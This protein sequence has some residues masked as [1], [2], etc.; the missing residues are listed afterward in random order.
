[1]KSELL[2]YLNQ[3]IHE[4]EQAHAPVFLHF[5]VK[6]IGFILDFEICV[7]VRTNKTKNVWVYI[8]QTEI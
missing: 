3:V 6:K 7:T 5:R 1:L 4:S 8:L 2:L